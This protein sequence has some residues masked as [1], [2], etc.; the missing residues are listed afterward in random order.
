M[1]PISNIF[2]LFQGIA[3]L[4]LR[5]SCTKTLSCRNVVKYRTNGDIVETLTPEQL[6]RL[7]ELDAA[8]L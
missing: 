5:N 7:R 2:V 6:Y 8:A 1:A 3:M 4:M